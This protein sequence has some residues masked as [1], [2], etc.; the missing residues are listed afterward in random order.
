[1]NAARTFLSCGLLL[2]VL[3]GGLRATAPEDEIFRG[4]KV[5]W[6]R[7]RTSSEYWDRHSERDVKMLDLMRRT[8][9]L[10]IDNEWRSAGADRLED[11]CEFPFLFSQSIAPLGEVEARNLAE[12]LRRGGFLLIDACANVSVT[13]NPDVFFKRQVAVLKKH[14]PQLRIVTL[15]PNHEVFSIFFNMSERPPQT[16]TPG[17]RNWIDGP[18]TFPLRAVLVGDRMVAVIALNGFQCGWGGF[19]GQQNAVNCIQMVTNIY[20]YAM[21]R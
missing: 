13:P 14:F 5:Q 9:S 1:M 6:A 20:V 8:T 21:T 4:G 15:E 12:Y 19:G 11:L 10:N 2:A 3:G 16:R 17:N 18:T 7:L